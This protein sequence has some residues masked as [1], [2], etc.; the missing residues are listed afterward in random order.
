MAIVWPCTLSVDA[1]SAAGREVE[2]PRAQCPDCSEPM[3][4][5]RATSA[6]AIRPPRGGCLQDL[7]PPGPLCGPAETHALLPAFVPPRTGSTRSRRSAPCS[8][9]WSKAPTGS[10]RRRRV[11]MSPHHGTG[12]GARF[13]RNAQR[14]AVAFAACAWSSAGP[15][16]HRRRRPDELRPS[17]MAA[18]WR[19]ASALPGWLVSRS[20]ALRS[21]VC[22]GTFLSANTNSPWLIIGKRRF[23][24]PVP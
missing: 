5:G 16:S 6:R 10:A 11:T 14:L 2:V 4:S 19:A 12:M 3:G 9:R 13:S 8:R 20:M 24:P 23:M 21:S 22:G 7:G 15:P 1:Y 18:A 17:G